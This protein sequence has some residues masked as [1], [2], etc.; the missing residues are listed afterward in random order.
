MDLFKFMVALLTALRPPEDSSDRRA[1]LAWRWTV[2]MLLGC[3]ILI[4]VGGLAWAQGWLPGVY[5]VATK[6]DIKDV[7]QTASVNVTSLGKRMDRIETTV[8]NIS[9]QILR[10][11]IQT[12]LTNSCTAQARSNQDALDRANRALFG[13][14]G[15]EGLLEQYQQMT[16]RP[17][18]VP[19]CSSILISPT[20]HP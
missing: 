2:A 14:D 9:L 18:S 17:F 8:N 6:E 12:E 7:A 10:S 11:S 5:G 1:D 13:Q 4:S 19:P 3:G 16:A 20:P 15:Q